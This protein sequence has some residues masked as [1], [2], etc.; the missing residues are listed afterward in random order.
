ML[1]LNAP[2]AP[3]EEAPVT[4]S[5][6]PEALEAIADGIREKC[7]DRP[8]GEIRFWKFAVV[9]PSDQLYRLVSVH[10]EGE[11]LD[12]VF[13]HDSRK[14]LPGVISVWQPAGLI[15]DGAGVLGLRGAARVRLDE[16][17]AT[18]EGDRY[19]VKTP[20]GEGDFA[21]EDSPALTL[22]R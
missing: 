4:A 19:R 10:A 2:N 3:V 5:T 14:G 16:N 12:L 11:R 21:A 13:V 15:V 18:R 6:G 9:R 17:A 8:F 22:G 7:L 20:R 1:L